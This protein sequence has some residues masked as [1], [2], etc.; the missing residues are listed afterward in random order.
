MS[1]EPGR[2]GMLE[3]DRQNAGWTTM[4]LEQIRAFLEASEPLRFEGQNRRGGLRLGYADI[5]AAAL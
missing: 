3:I 5:E 4:S 1:L 2:L